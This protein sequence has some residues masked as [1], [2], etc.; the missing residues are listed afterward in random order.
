MFQE[1]QVPARRD[2]RRHVGV[3]RV[4]VLCQ[5]RDPLLPGD[6]LT[7][8]VGPDRDGGDPGLQEPGTRLELLGPRVGRPLFGHGLRAER[9]VREEPVVEGALDEALLVEGE[10]GRG[11]AQDEVG[12]VR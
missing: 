7:H 4:G 1:E 11:Y 9:E 2:A 10:D 3:G 12:H 5:L 8:R 6:R